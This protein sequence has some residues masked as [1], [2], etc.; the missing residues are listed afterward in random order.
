VL[1]GCLR[2]SVVAHAYDDFHV[3]SYILYIIYIYI[4]IDG[5]THSSLLLAPYYVLGLDVGRH[6]ADSLLGKY[7]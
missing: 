2:E 1:K 7:E 5:L 4:H 6:D 3:T